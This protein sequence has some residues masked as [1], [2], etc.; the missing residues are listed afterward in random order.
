MAPE[1]PEVK[2]KRLYWTLALANE[3]AV[4]L[5]AY[6]MIAGDTRTAAMLGS[7]WPWP[8]SCRLRKMNI[9]TEGDPY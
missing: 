8:Q 2:P 5:D 6:L 3:A 1:S 4:C 7:V 9:A